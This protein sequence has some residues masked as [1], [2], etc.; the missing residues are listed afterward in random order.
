MSD[1]KLTQP[2]AQDQVPPTP[3]RC[4]TGAIFSGAL[5]YAMYSLMISIA[6]TFA[7]KPI[8]SDNP[9]VINIGS[10]VRTLVVG[11]VALGTGIFGIVGIG[12]LALAIQLLVHQ[13]TKAKN[14]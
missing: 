1:P 14:S 6:T 11:V 8:H 13:L 4:M 12:L 9:M 7:T 10:A 3:L 5:A 2:E